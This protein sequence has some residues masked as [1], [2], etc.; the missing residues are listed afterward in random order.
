MSTHGSISR[1]LRVV[2]LT[3]IGVVTA[4]AMAQAQ[5]VSPVP[6]A[7]APIGWLGA[8]E[9]VYRDD[10]SAPTTWTISDDEFGRTAYEVG[11]LV[12][13]VAQ[14]GSSL[15]DDHRLPEA[16]AVLRV[17]ALVSG[18]DGAG[19]AGVACGSSLGLP[20]YL[21]AAVSDQADWV[22][23]RIIDGRLQ[24]IDRGPIPGDIDE[25][26]VRVGIECAS[27]PEEGGDH[28]LVTLDGRA[29][30]LPAFDIPVGPYDK[31]T[32]LVTSDV[33]P[34]SVVFDDLVVHAG[35][36]YERRQQDRDPT[37]PST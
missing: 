33:A 2:A 30:T 13:T 8:A 3:A 15:W 20:R 1:P 27:S 21:F 26:N 11:S 23:G 7:D 29:M 12:V 32:L 10:F 34:V 5:S 19:G 18:L 4:G 22:F 31:A 36:V 37:K 24:V 9:E 35:D 6:S 28:V 17:E 14:D 25:G 16:H